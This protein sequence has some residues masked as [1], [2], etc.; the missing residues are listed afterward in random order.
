[1]TRTDRYPP[2]EARQ[3][4]LSDLEPLELVQ[5][6]MPRWLLDA[7]PDIIDA[8]NAAMAQ[9]RLWHGRVGKKFSELQSVETYCGTL[10]AAE[11]MYAFGPSLDIHRDYLAAVHVHVVTDNTLL[12]TVRHTTV[13]D[14]PKTLLWA[15]LQNFSVDES[16]A[17]GFHPQSKILHGGHPA[18]PSPILPHE[19][20]ALCRRLDLGL[21]YQLY[22]QWF[23]GVAAPGIQSPN[24]T[25]LATERNLRQLK[26]SDMQVDAHIAFLKKNIGQT[27][28]SALL[29]MLAL[30]TDAASTASV[31][32]DG[33]PI[34]HSSMSIL[35]T[36]IDGVVIFSADS[37]L[38]HPGQRLI[39]YIPNDP[40]APF[41]E[42][43]TLQVFTD[44]LKHRLRDPAYA[45][46]FAR[47]VALKDRAGF[48]QKVK[49][50]PEVLF[51]TAAP[52]GMSAAQYLTSVQLK[53]MFADAQVLAVPT[54]VLDQQ[55]REARWQAYKNAGLLLINV[56][57]LFVPVL[58]DVMLAV[59]IGQMLKEV[60]EGVEDWAHGDV[61][62][63]REHLLN[64][65][66][67][68]AV[69]GAI[70][71]GAAAVGTLASRLSQA[72]RN[73]FE[74]FE[75]IQRDDGS[76]RLWN[77]QLEPYEHKTAGERQHR[78]DAQGFFKYQGADCVQVNGKHYRA[79][80]D[81][82]LNQWRIAHP[83]RPTAF[84]PALLHNRQ[85]AWQH[86]HERPLEWDAS[87]TLMG[88]LGGPAV[89]LDAQSLEHV[90]LLT[91]T[92]HG[93]LR[94]VHLHNLAPPPLLRI[95]LKRF[96]IDRQIT[97]FI[98]QM[99][100]HEYNAQR[101]ADLQLQLLPLMPGWPVGKGLAMAD[102]SGR[103]LAHAGSSVARINLT[104]AMLEQGTL[105]DTVLGALSQTEINGLLG[106]EGSTSGDVAQRLAQAMGAYA[107]DN[108]SSV[109]GHLYGQFDVSTSPQAIPIERAFAGLPRSVAQNLVESA[110]DSQRELLRTAKVP[111]A[112]GEMARL[113]L[114][115]SRINRALEG[116]YLPFL[117]GA[118]TD[119]LTLHFL[120]RLHGL[121]ADAT[122]EI[123]EN[124][125]L[126]TVTHRWGNV[127]AKGARVLVKTAQGY[128]RYTP[129][130]SMQVLEPG[131]PVPLLNALFTSLTPDERL[132]MGFALPADAT[133]F[134]A[135]LGK[136]AAQARQESAGVLG[137]QPIKP[138]FKP[139]V[140]LPSGQ[141][142]YPLCGLDPGG[143]SAALQ[144]RVRDIYPDI[145]NEQVLIYL[146][147]LIERG[148]D[149]L[150]VLRQRKRERLALVQS[151][152]RWI[153]ATPIE[154]LVTNTVHDYSEDRYQIAVLIQRSW[155]KS[156]K[157]LP[158]A[159]PDEVYSLNLGGFRLDSLPALPDLADF[160]HVR[161][162]KLS[163]MDCR[164][165]AG[166]FLEHFSGVVSL[167]MDNN[168]MTRFPAQLMHLPHLQ[169]LSLARNQL[170][171][172]AENMEVLSTL[173]RLEVLNLNDNVLG[174]LLSFNG[175]AY[176]RRVY[177]R[178]S[179]LDQWPQGLISRPLLESADLR[180][181]RITE[182]PEHV[183]LASPTF[184]RH[185]SLSGNPLSAASRLR[186]ARNVMQGGSSMGIRSE[187]L[188]S[189][190][191]AFEFWTVGITSQER[192]RRELLWN[193][194]RA[195][196][197]ADD[198]FV[199][200]SR[201][202]ST[203]DAQSVRHDLSRRVW[204]M[205]EAANE[206]S[207]LRRDVLDIAASP[208]SC[209]DSVA[210]IFSAMEVQMELAAVSR[211]ASLEVGQLLTLGKKQF[212]LH[213]L[214]Q[215]A[216]AHFKRQLAAGEAAD[217]LEVHLAYRIGLAADLD[218]PGQ[219]RN[220]SFG[221]LAGVTQADLEVAKFEVENA[222][223]TP[224]LNTF[225]STQQFWKDYLI[226][227]SKAQYSALTKPHFDSL[228]EL[229]LNSPQMTDE[230][231][232]RRVAEIRHQMDGVVD[233]WCLEKTN[234]LLD[235]L[236]RSGEES[237][238]L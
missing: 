185:I 134:N 158:W 51:L 14:E 27:A 195:E 238:A 73:H 61:D 229:L 57:A 126:G 20:A 214:S 40:V 67:D 48:M 59:A 169:R 94:R 159:N 84:K 12:L 60:Y 188:M 31:Q 58:G 204:E 109:F 64:V 81:S 186:L 89:S 91:D 165:I 151:L 82:S 113:Y 149:P 178:R 180:E 69:N 209:S 215:I 28:Y 104:P 11:V 101:W 201:L 233:A 219:P 29:A 153:N 123:R 232:L 107:R 173:N 53:N 183:Y 217:E 49:A 122:L 6:H 148:L 16:Q 35:D 55:E 38:L 41:F 211:D 26:T 142:G 54:G 135:A 5:S 117:A 235:A 156:P 145:N 197:A 157:H 56:A 86:A 206:S 88:R 237:T 166:S 97:A 154:Q 32:L 77:K 46:F 160:S 174:P 202:T 130:G 70:A 143:Y 34:F 193:A 187:E 68:I 196:P 74:G 83:A 66:R 87:A 226:K 175:L 44:E 13:R 228:G 100:T 207:V 124:S 231:Y 111:L 224:E 194:L 212:R 42:F 9:S 106:Q 227:T 216:A 30:A 62:H 8:L 200:I 128:Q 52:L 141:T 213:K 37:L 198:F 218:L 80:F 205:I 208:R 93:L 115:E 47:F 129:R 108:R 3:S 118:D 119:Q 39:A 234:A 167:E 21:K 222:E 230:R 164:D 110:T 1:M 43:S 112:L 96:E 114:R 221:R 92:P 190:A 24:A 95:S 210:F 199:V 4:T 36:V 127:E 138:V 162:L 121:P 223:R 181:N 182:I 72:T 203:A 63:A 155:H 225:I 131:G 172:S 147:G 75:P 45:D 139:P 99:S 25:Q 103:S 184:T 171:M 90:R 22:L 133:Q 7:P 220:M 2:L 17:D 116:F 144:R 105:L 79:E 120:A 19:I 65:A 140:T 132:A 191:A 189:E 18:R 168:R 10:L 23:L 125:L 152:Q 176:L 15:A 85:G 78:A 136:L 161:E 146:D 150:N 177:L 33:K 179:G 102:S 192:R 98:E 71:V 50:H 236:E 170:Y 137:M 76:A 163:N